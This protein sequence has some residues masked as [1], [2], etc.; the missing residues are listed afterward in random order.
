MRLKK[1]TRTTTPTSHMI[2][3]KKA[4]KRIMDA[5]KTLE[6]RMCPVCWDNFAIGTN[7]EIS[8]L[9]CIH[10]HPLCRMCVIKLLV[11]SHGMVTYECPVC[12][13]LSFVPSKALI[14]LLNTAA[15]YD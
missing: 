9:S 11:E 4:H 10:G 2:L 6:T 15:F 13:A 3:L 1:H 5:S 12:R 7:G 14:T 8:G